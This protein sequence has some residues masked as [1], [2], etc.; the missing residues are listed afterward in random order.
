MKVFGAVTAA[1]GT[2]AG[3]TGE[4]FASSAEADR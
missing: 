3:E 1:F 2:E 4:G